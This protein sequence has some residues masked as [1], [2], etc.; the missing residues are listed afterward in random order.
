M[1]AST[2]SHTNLYCEVFNRREA[3]NHSTAADISHADFKL[4]PLSGLQISATRASSHLLR[5]KPR[6][7][8]IC[9]A[10]QDM[11]TLVRMGQQAVWLFDGGVELPIGSA[12]K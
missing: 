11:L 10:G 7:S 6:L 4:E 1:I 8:E 12:M 2:D 9:K 5:Q 3:T